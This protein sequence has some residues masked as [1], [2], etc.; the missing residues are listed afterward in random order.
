MGSELAK[1]APMALGG[2]KRMKGTPAPRVTA[3]QMIRIQAPK[4]AGMIRRSAVLARLTLGRNEDSK[5]THRQASSQAAVS[6][7]KYGASAVPSKPAM[8]LIRS[9]AAA[10]APAN[11]K[12]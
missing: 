11:S 4:I 1:R 9:Q 7:R 6:S 5:A 10:W 8:P 12:M 2:G 3:S